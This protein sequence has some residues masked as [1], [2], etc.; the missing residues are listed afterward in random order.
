MGLQILS[1][2]SGVFKITTTFYGP[3]AVGP[4]KGKQHNALDYSTPIGTPIYAVTDGVIARADA[5]D[6]GGGNIIQLDNTQ[7]GLTAIYA[8]LS[9]MYVKPG[10]IVHAGQVIGSTGNTGTLTTGP[11]LYFETRLNG[12]PVDPIP[13]INGLVNPADVQ[14]TLISTPTLTLDQ[15]VALILK[16]IPG[17]KALGNPGYVAIPD[18]FSGCPTGATAYQFPTIG[19]PSGT[20]V[21]YVSD[22]AK[23][24]WQDIVGGGEA[25]GGAVIATGAFLGK[26]ADPAHWAKFLAIAGG[27]GMIVWGGVIL[28]QAT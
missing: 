8:H 15:A 22:A 19:N 27:V 26:L 18:S 14:A 9:D 5:K 25:V 6:L 24:P 1:P 23:L 2:L 21:C 16:N 7:A 3:I 20:H 13:L 28:Y 17:S 12:A 11:H 4:N 10:D